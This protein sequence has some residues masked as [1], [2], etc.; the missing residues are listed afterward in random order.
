MKYFLKILFLFSLYSCSDVKDTVISNSDNWRV[1]KKVKSTKVNEASSLIQKK[2]NPFLYSF[3]GRWFFVN[4]NIILFDDLFKLVTVFDVEGNVLNQYGGINISKLQDLWE[5]PYSIVSSD[6]GFISIFGRSVAYLDRSFRVK[7]IIDLR[8]NGNQNNL[9]MLEIP[10]PDNM[11]IY[12]LNERN[13]NYYYTSNNEILVS[14]E[15]EAPLFNPYNSNSYYKMARSFG[16]INLKESTVSPLP[17]IKSRMYKD[18]CCLTF[19]DASYITGDD[20]KYYVQF[21][22]DTLIYVYNQNFK[23]DYA[24]GSKGKYIPN[25]IMND[26]LDVAFEYEKYV[27]AEK[28]ANVFEGVFN[29]ENGQVGRIINNR[30]ENTKWI[31]LYKENE[32]DRQFVIPNTF[33]FIGVFKNIVYFIRENENEKS[34]ELC[35][36]K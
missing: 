18:T 27:K 6:S 31:Q 34:I 14:L 1:V 12:E 15:S 22:A 16:K 36:V 10:D 33:S 28:M 4:N 17:I 26:G 25:R 19:Q 5:R 11:N 32:L 29:L 9:S 30:T 23:P 3:S 13:R 35:T 2:I 20:K 24:F 7:K 8:F 21:A